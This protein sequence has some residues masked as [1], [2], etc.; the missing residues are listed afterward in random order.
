MAKTETCLN[1]VAALNEREN[2]IA[3]V[4]FKEYR[5]TDGVPPLPPAS[6]GPR[7]TSTSKTSTR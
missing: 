3:V 7:S 2:D 1:V 5:C 6:P 4:G